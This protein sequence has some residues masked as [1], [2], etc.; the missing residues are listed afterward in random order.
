MTVNE[1]SDKFQRLAHFALEI[2]PTEASRAWKFERGLRHNIKSKMSGKEWTKM[3]KTYEEA[4]LHEQTLE[5]EKKQSE[6]KNRKHNQK[7]K[8]S[9]PMKGKNFAATIAIAG[10]SVPQGSMALQRSAPATLPTPWRD[11]PAT[12]ACFPMQTVG[13]FMKR[14]FASADEGIADSYL[15][16]TSI[17]IPAPST[18]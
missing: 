5:K 3:K 4:L 11:G 18:K 16:T 2:V 7:G 13:S 9:R 17:K 10:E 12:N 14:L 1:Y 8:K 15:Q 6:Y